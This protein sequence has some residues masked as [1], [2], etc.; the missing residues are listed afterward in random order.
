MP[1]AGI[2]SQGFAVVPGVLSE[3]ENQTLVDTFDAI[4]RPGQRG[5]LHTPEIARLARSARLLA[6]VASHTSA[7]PRPVRAICFN[8]SPDVNWAVAWH[9]DLTLAVRERVDVEGF[10]PWSINEGVPH[11]QAPA[12]VLQRMLTIRLHLDDCNESNGALRVLPATHR[13]GRLSPPQIAKLRA[14]ISEVV[15]CVRAGG[16]VLMRPLLLHASGKSQGR[17][18]RR[19]L[20][21]EYAGGQ[22]PGGIEAVSD[23]KS[24]K[25]KA[26]SAETAPKQKAE[27]KLRV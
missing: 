15:C 11:T 25:E 18:H 4:S 16:A 21:I 27:L 19:V 13:L 7:D 26:Q 1:S 20:H 8:K 12:E 24:E 3:I 5:V 2:E 14:E 10:G 9:Q 23:P 6:L 17:G 22:L